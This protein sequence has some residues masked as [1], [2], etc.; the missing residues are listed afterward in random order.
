[1]NVNSYLAVLFTPSLCAW[2]CVRGMMSCIMVC[3]WVRLF[4]IFLLVTRACQQIHGKDI[5]L[6]VQQQA[7]ALQTPSLKA[8]LFWSIRAVCVY[9]CATFDFVCRCARVC[10]NEC[11]QRFM[12]LTSIRKLNDRCKDSIWKP[13]LIIIIVVEEWQLGLACPQASSVIW[14]QFAYSV[15]INNMDLHIQ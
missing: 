4:V 12:A 9:L 6:H 1:M 5:W 11:F 13:A 10:Q 14:R 7:E 2:E 15:I 8:A 3:M